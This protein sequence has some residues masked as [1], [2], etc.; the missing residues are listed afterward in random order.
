MPL[1]SVQ[2]NRRRHLASAI[3]QDLL[4]VLRGVRLRGLILHHTLSDLVHPWRV[5][6][7]HIGAL[8][9]A[10][11]LARPVRHILAARQ[12]GTRGLAAAH[13][14]RHDVTRADGTGVESI[15][16]QVRMPGV[17]HGVEVLAQVAATSRAIS[18][19]Q[20]LVRLG[21]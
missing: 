19:L 15:G 1:V 5:L 10:R 2:I 4:I 8:L 6:R 20:F 12:R 18:S 13:L 21:V 7:V 17:A 14:Q 3:G 16:R 11:L 9:T